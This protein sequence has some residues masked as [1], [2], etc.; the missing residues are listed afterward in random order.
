MDRSRLIGL[1]AN[2]KYKEKMKK[3]NEDENKAGTKK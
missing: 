2:Y 3:Q 1:M